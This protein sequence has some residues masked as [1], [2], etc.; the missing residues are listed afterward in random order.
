M[1]CTKSDTSP[2]TVAPLRRCAVAFSSSCFAFPA[3]VAQSLAVAVLRLL[4]FGVP[5]LLLQ[6]P[7]P[8]NYA[9]VAGTIGNV[10]TN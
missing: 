6:V 8:L 2:R 9:Q 10:T 4:Q 3:A 7:L 5:P 1:D